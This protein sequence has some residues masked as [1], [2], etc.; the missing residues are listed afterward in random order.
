MPWL[1]DRLEQL[2]EWKQLHL[3]SVEVSRLRR[4]YRPGLLMIGDAAHVIS[5]IGGLG[6]NMA[7]QDAVTVANRLTR[8]LQQGRVRTRDLAAVQRGRAWQI[9]A[10]QAQQVVEERQVTNVMG[11]PQAAHVPMLLLRVI[12]RLPLLRRLP[13]YV[14]AYGLKPVRLNRQLHAALREG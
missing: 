1:A 14:T 12:Q 11:Q 13:A 3:L 5:P 6:I 7:I 8:P 4:W 9:A 2:T 10:L